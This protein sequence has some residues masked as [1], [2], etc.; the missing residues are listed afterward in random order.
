MLR[1]KFPVVQCWAVNQPNRLTKSHN[2]VVLTILSCLKC[3][4][5]NIC[6]ISALFFPQIYTW[7]SLLLRPWRTSKYRWGGVI[8]N[9]NHGQRMAAPTYPQFFSEKQKI[10]K[11][12]QW[13]FRRIG[14]FMFLLCFVILWKLINHSVPLSSL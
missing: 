2:V 9:K 8:E 4:F 1:R 10:L 11:N 14:K 3:F 6:V 7:M 13:G 12:I 5:L